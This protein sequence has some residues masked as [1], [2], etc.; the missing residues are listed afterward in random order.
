MIMF[1]LVEYKIECSQH[2]RNV[3]CAIQLDG[4]F[5]VISIKETYSTH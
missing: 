3:Q 2:F 5:C 4:Y 1:N